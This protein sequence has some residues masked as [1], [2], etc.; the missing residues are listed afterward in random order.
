LKQITDVNQ[1]LQSETPKIPILL[2]R[3]A[4]LYKLILKCFIQNDVI[5]RT[6]FC[7]IDVRNPRNYKQIENIY[8][9]GNVD[10]FLKNP[11]NSEFL[12]NNE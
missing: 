1:E 2:D 10:T 6:N 3:V 12:M 4:C 5:Q 11:E 7:L 9:G 8:F